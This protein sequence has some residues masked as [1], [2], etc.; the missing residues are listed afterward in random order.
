MEV[1][2]SEQEQLE[3][4]KKW[5]KENGLAVVL[6]LG[7]GLGGLFGWRWWQGEKLGHAEQAST[8]YQQVVSALLSERVAEAQ[9]AGDTLKRDYADTVYAA[10]AALSLARV[11]VEAGRLA[12][13]EV[14]LR[15]VLEHGRQPAVV[16]TARERLARL[17]LAQDRADEAWTLLEAAEV[18]R[19]SA[20]LAELRG[21]VRL[22]QGQADAAREL[23]QRALLLAPV[24]PDSDTTPLQLKLDDLGGQAAVTP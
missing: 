22:A 7:L 6:G 10:L 5:W 15:W 3:A 1:Y 18:V 13:A 2:S 24:D 16:E 14:Q 20:A 4:I 9:G 19:E 12:E 11:E 21:D 8:G 23:Y 17:L